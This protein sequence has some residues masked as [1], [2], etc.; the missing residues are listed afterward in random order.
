MLTTE[1]LTALR[2]IIAREDLP[3]PTAAGIAA[4][5]VVQLHPA[6]DRTFG[7]MLALVTRAAPYELR[8]VL[9]RPHRGGC[10]EAQLRLSPANVQRIGR[11]SSCPTSN[12]ARRCETRGLA[13]RYAPC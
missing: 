5:D 9:L 2:A 12:F 3:A 1:E 8:A 6:A 13:C 11:A 7:G 10:Q 4:G